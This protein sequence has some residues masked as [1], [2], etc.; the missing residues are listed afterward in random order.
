MSMKNLKINIIVL[1]MTISVLSSIIEA[2]ACTKFVYTGDN[3]IVLTGRTADWAGKLD[4]NIWLFPRGI[5]RNGLAGKNSAKWTSKYGSIATS[6]H[7]MMTIDGVNEKG[8]TMGIL[9]LKESEFIPQNKAGRRK[10]L[11]ISL[12]GQYFLDNFATVEEAVEAMKKDKIYVVPLKVAGSES[13][14]MHLAI[15]DS[16]GDF[17]V[18]E[19]TGEKLHIYHNKN[20]KVVTNS[21]KYS[22]QMAIDNYWNSVNGKN[23]LPGTSNSS[24]RF[25]RAFY[26]L[27]KL[28][29]TKDID[30]ATAYVLSLIRNVSSPLGIENGSQNQEES[31]TIW[32]TI[33]NHRDMTYF[34]ES[35]YKSYGFTID[36]T[37]INFNKDQK[38][39]VIDMENG[40]YYFGD[41]TDKFKEAKSF[42][43]FPSDDKLIEV[44]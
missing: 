24:D 25:A 36:L 41:A 34:F 1:V 10:A 40:K 5:K 4:S 2:K 21:P 37:K 6:V 27:N 17:A 16:K 38:I 44:K 22:S 29:K 28:P 18:F 35:A 19:Y 23:F 39:Q 26:Y 30:L 3:N 8:L 9:R 43:F 42:N 7:D 15:S 33:T 14:G 31:A 11:G 13:S 32:R 20:F 12:W